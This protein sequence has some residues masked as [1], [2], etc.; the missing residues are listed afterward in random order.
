MLISLGYNKNSGETILFV[1]SSLDFYV[2]TNMGNVLGK[3]FISEMIN[4]IQCE[5]KFAFE[6]AETELFSLHDV[7]IVTGKL[8]GY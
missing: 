7:A 2:N 4:L 6:V 5:G 8:M 1:E 3:V